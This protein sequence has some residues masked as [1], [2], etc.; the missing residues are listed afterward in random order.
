MIYRTF[1]ISSGNFLE[2]D[3]NEL[4]EIFLNSGFPL[5]FIERQMKDFFK[6]QRETKFKLFGPQAKNISFG[7]NY[8]NENFQK[9]IKKVSSLTEKFVP[10]NVKIKYYY[11]R[12]RCLNS[13]FFEKLQKL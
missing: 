3:L 6:Q 12:N 7:I 1:K 10:S 5:K 2:K 8:I 13:I 9:F 11:K 4:K